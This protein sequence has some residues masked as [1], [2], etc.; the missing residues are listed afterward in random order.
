[1]YSTFVFVHVKWSVKG[2]YI[3]MIVIDLTHHAT[4][5][6]V[7]VTESVFHNL[8]SSRS[9]IA[10]GCRRGVELLININWDTIH[11]S[12]LNQ[13]WP[14]GSDL[15]LT[16]G[17]RGFDSRARSLLNIQNYVRTAFYKTKYDLL[18]CKGNLHDWVNRCAKPANPHS[19]SEVVIFKPDFLW[20][21]TFSNKQSF[22]FI[23][24][25]KSREYR[26][27][28]P[29]YYFGLHRQIEVKY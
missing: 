24:R 25:V 10:N 22:Q 15:C 3:Q 29:S 1:M 13:W 23:I 2:C 6:S 19:A 26:F 17:D 5:S 27:T 14:I 16:R 9:W 28:P 4:S 7:L 18:N 8:Y 20:L 12:R 11:V 21:S